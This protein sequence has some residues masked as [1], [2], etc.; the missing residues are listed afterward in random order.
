M[1]LGASLCISRS[2]MLSPPS[3]PSSS[4]GSSRIGGAT[5]TFLRGDEE[6]GLSKVEVNFLFLDGVR[7]TSL[8]KG[9]ERGWGSELSDVRA[10]A[11]PDRFRVEPAISCKARRF[12]LIPS[13][14]FNALRVER[15]V[16][17]LR[18]DL[19]VTGGGLLGFRQLSTSDTIDGGDDGKH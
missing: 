9:L 6:S 7:L 13:S 5:R 17:N 14:L 19:G 12:V 18:N 15:G 1:S 4:F 2:I 10:N 8:D 11:G 3:L 16:K